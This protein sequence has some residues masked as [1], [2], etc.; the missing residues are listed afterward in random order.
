MKRAL[1]LLTISVLL[2][3]VGLD[4]VRA[5]GAAPQPAG[6]ALPAE[7]REPITA[8]AEAARP[9]RVSGYA[10]LAAA[11]LPPLAL[12]FALAWRR[13]WLADE[14]RKP[15]AARRALLR[16]L[17]RAARRDGVPSAGELEVWRTQVLRLV[18]LDRA[19]PSP[20][21]V[22]AHIRGNAGAD[23]A[24][25]WQETE[26]A[27]YSPRAAVRGDWLARALEATRQFRGPRPPPPGPWRRS[28][29]LPVTALAIVTA[30]SGPQP[31]RADPAEAYRAGR[32]AEAAEEWRHDLGSRPGNWAA[33]HN[34]GLV[35]AREN[36]WGLAAAHEV[37][38]Y[39]LKP[40]NPS[41]DAALRL[42]LTKVEAP[43]PVLLQLLVGPWH[44]RVVARLSPARWEGLARVGAAIAALALAAAVAACYLSPNKRRACRLSLAIAV[45][46]AGV[47]VVALASVRRYGA[48]ADPLAAVV[49]APVELRAIPSD[50][51]ARQRPLTLPPGTVV[52]VDRSFLGWDHVT[53][54]G[55]LSGWIRTDALVWLYRPRD[56]SRVRAD[57]AAEEN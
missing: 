52:V 24:A 34:L 42:A 41:V 5:Q 49:A 54:V 53:V 9:T 37:A 13:A 55:N 11:S 47:A 2:L 50:M 14:T 8:A 57:Y 20:A 7:L 16:L 28:H 46:A 44:D 51:V 48:L 38:A 15:R 31:A 12:W 40:D 3:W 32:Y 22:A 17:K 56:R 10:L 33:H 30:S 21:E 35:A 43:D 39:L 6:F 4:A 18:R 25:L 27:L 26:E 1:Q 29:W 45:M 19:A 36:Q 23:W